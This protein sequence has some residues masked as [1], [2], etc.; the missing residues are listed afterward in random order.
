[1]EWLSLIAVAPSL[2]LLILSERRQLT[3]ERDLRDARGA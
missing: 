1:M 2:V 3:T